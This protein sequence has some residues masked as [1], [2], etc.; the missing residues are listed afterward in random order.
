MRDGD[1]NSTEPLVEPLTSREREVLGLLAEGRSGLE[2]AQQLTLAPSSVKWHIQQL[3]GK[4]GVNRRQHALLRARALGLLG[5]ATSTVA[6]PPPDAPPTPPAR[7]NLPMA[8]TR[9]FGREPEIIQLRELLAE[10]RL[11]TVTGTGGVGKTRLALRVAEDLVAGFRDGIWLIELAP[12]SDPALVPQAVAV[13]LGVREDPGRPFVEPLIRFL[14]G[15]QLLLLLD[16][17]EHLLAACAELAD[18]LLRACPRLT[19]LATSREPLNSAGE[20]VFTAPSLPFP[21]PDQALSVEHASAY[22]A[23]RLFVDRARM[24]HPNYQVTPGNVAWLGR[25]CDRLDGVPLAIEMAAARMNLLT[26]KQLAG[27]LDDAFAVLTSGRRTALPRQQTLRATLDWGYALLNAAERL[28]LQRLSVFAGGFT[29]EAAEAV[30][31]G[32]GLAAGRVLE[33]LAALV[34]KS[35]VVA[36]RRQGAETRYR[37]LETVRQYVWEKI[38]AAGEATALRTRHLDYFLRL[39]EEG[40]AQLKRPAQMLELDQLESELDNIRAAMVHSRAPL[41]E[42]REEKGLRLV[43]ALL[44][45]WFV[46]G[47]NREMHDWLEETLA[48]RSVPD[49][50]LI[51]AQALNAIGRLASEP[52]D[53]ARARVGIEE[54]IEIFRESGSAG[55]RGLAY[56][57]IL[58]GDLAHAQGDFAPRIL[59]TEESVEIFRELGDKWGLAFAL[60]HLAPTRDPLVNYQPR[61]AN[62]EP[63]LLPRFAPAARNDHT[64]ERALFEESLALFREL[65]DR[66]FQGEVLASMA[67][68]AF[69]CGDRALGRTMTEECLAIHGELGD[70]SATASSLVFLGND[71]LVDDDLERATALYEQS[72]AISQNLKRQSSIAQI[73][74]NLGEVARRRGDYQQAAKLLADSSALRQASHHRGNI[75]ASLDGQGRVAG[76]QGDLTTARSLQMKALSVRL[77]TGHPISL[78]YSSHALAI[79]AA[80]QHQPERAARLFGAAEPYHSALYSNWA[81]LPIWRAEHERGVAAVRA[82]LGEAATA[83]LLAEGVNMTLDQAVAYAAGQALDPTTP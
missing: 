57:L 78:S 7:H 25:I 17:C 19:I 56:A 42:A 5:T 1:I 47:H 43:L 11:V 34:A 77:E 16:N 22:A 29:L 46:R 65:G 52:S 31:V 68:M 26:A 73:Y 72:L 66:R 8:L 30:C 79:L 41:D 83:D 61:S 50:S 14:R 60:H 71:A 74:C 20:A 23:V 53:I 38:Q 70:M 49:R 36:D 35:L 59:L 6:A 18:R 12:L 9:F 44:Q 10:Y 4:L 64:V 82:Q 21:D 55:Q 15:R 67:Q 69:C 54:S 40:E 33:T 62:G 51:R 80:A 81:A 48:R 32:D 27:R 76:S 37:L 2:I 39:A 13:A 63:P 58:L 28:L 45:L 75:A 3:Y 24:V